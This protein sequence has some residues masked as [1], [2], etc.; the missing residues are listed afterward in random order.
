[1]LSRFGIEVPKNISDS[2]VLGT[3]VSHYRPINAEF[4]FTAK[5]IGFEF[6]STQTFDP[7]TAI[8]SVSIYLV[9][10]ISQQNY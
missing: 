8:F 5:V 7:N 6:Y 1:M 4:K 10:S 9:R 2:V 3:T